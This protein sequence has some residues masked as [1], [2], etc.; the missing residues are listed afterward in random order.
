[1]TIPITAGPLAV[2]RF[3]GNQPGMQLAL[4]PIYR[5]RKSVL[6]H[7]APL[8]SGWAETP[9]PPSAFLHVVSTVAPASPQWVTQE[10]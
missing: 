9:L 4:P 2:W 3:K 8:G 7:Y 6:G 1:M 10:G 5:E